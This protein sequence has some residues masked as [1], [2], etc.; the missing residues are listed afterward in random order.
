MNNR[1]KDVHVHVDFNLGDELRGQVVA[2]LSTASWAIK[3][4]NGPESWSGRLNSRAARLYDLGDEDSFWVYGLN[5]KEHI[6][7]LSDSGFGRLPISDRMRSRYILALRALIQL[8]SQDDTHS[9]IEVEHL[10][11]VKGIFNRCIRKDQWDWLTVYKTLGCPPIASLR[12]LVTLVAE[13]RRSI[14]ESKHG[15]SSE[16]IDQIKRTA[17]HINIQGALAAISKD[18]PRLQ[19]ALSFERNTVDSGISSSNVVGPERDPYILSQISRAK[20]EAANRIHEATLLTLVKHLEDRGYMV[21]RSVLIDAYCRLKSGPAIFEVKSINASNERSQCRHAL[22]QLYEYRYLHSLP[23]AS[24][25]LV[26][27]N[28]PSIPWTAEFLEKD[29]GVKVIWVED[30]ALCGNYAAELM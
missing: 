29:R 23:E 19:G 20:M 30:G 4:L 16:L 28:R 12:E 1:A 15:V 9:E 11:E 14:R 27:S 24:L 18:V 17:N 7:I 21:E 13:L 6:A 26:L 2:Q 5:T 22:S 10:S 8:T 3:L 25:W